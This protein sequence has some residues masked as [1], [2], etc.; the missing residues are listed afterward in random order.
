LG[1]GH[2]GSSRAAT[3]IQDTVNIA[4]EG[5]QQGTEAF[6]MKRDAL[7][8]P[9]DERF[10]CRGSCGCECDSAI[11]IVN[12]ARGRTGSDQISEFR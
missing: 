8:L 6:L 1:D 3:D 12:I 10:A 4:H 9:V 7:D 11:G 2:C 5:F